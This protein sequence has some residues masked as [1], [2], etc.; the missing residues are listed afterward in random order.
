MI[1]RNLCSSRWLVNGT[2]ETI[3]D[4]IWNDGAEDPF[5]TM[6]VVRDKYDSSGEHENQQSTRGF[7]GS[8]M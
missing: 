7:R 3:L 2:M 8:T 4:M 5:D 6:P 1:T